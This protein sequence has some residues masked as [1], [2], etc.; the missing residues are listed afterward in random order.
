MT[1]TATVTH[2]YS[3]RADGPSPLAAKL[4]SDAAS[5]LDQ[6]RYSQQPVFDTPQRSE[7]SQTNIFLIAAHVI[8]AASRSRIYTIRRHRTNISAGF[9]RRTTHAQPES[10]SALDTR[11]LWEVSY[12]LFDEEPKNHRT[13]HDRSVEREPAFLAVLV[14]CSTDAVEFLLDHELYAHS[15]L[16]LSESRTFP[17][18]SWLFAVFNWS[19]RHDRKNHSTLCHI[20]RPQTRAVVSTPE[21]KAARPSGCVLLTFCPF[22]SHLLWPFRSLEDLTLWI[23]KLW[24]GVTPKIASYLRGQE[25]IHKLCQPIDIFVRISFHKCHE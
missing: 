13:L 18:P 4:D 22:S 9:S 7:E 3:H 14:C 12:I 24:A 20:V 21:V 11:Y 1:N 16:D 17:S 10:L 8:I 2:S 25:Y 6:K 15:T 5:R 23:F 19:A